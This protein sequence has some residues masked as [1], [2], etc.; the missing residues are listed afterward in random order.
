[1]VKQGEAGNRQ[2][3][4]CP[5]GKGGPRRRARQLNRATCS[6]KESFVGLKAG[7]RGAANLCEGRDGSLPDTFPLREELPGNDQ[8]PALAPALHPLPGAFKRNLC[9]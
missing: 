5:E 6:L 9:S 2:R 7:K 1:M 8:Q 4:V 3:V